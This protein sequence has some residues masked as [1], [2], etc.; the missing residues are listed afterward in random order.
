[1]SEGVGGDQCVKDGP[2]VEGTAYGKAAS[3][4]SNDFWR[5]R[6]VPFSL[7]LLVTIPS[8]G[9]RARISFGPARVEHGVPHL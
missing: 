3:L 7:T 5:V 2:H 4:H 6:S 1:M 8:M 9:L